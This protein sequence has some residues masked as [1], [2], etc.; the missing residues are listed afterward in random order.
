MLADEFGSLSNLP[1]QDVQNFVAKID[2][3]L[4]GS[5]LIQPR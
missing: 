4:Y 1:Y 5:Y 3:T 2:G